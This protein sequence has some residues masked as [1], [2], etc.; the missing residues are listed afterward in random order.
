MRLA[1]EVRLLMVSKSRWLPAAR[2]GNE[3]LAQLALIIAQGDPPVHYLQ[4]S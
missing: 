3:H 1:A 4:I 2:I